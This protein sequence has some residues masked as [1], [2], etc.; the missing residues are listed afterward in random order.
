MAVVA[1]EHKGAGTADCKLA[2]IPVKV[3]ASKGS[4][5]FKT[6]AFL[7]PEA[8]P[9]SETAEYSLQTIRDGQFLLVRRIYTG[10]RILRNGHT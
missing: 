6:Y 1:T 8:Q 5:V 3:K 10:N 7:N 9:H 2:I 4:R